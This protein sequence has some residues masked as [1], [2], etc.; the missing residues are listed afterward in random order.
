MSL[1]SSTIMPS[2]TFRHISVMVFF[3]ALLMGFCAFGLISVTSIISGWTKDI[4][5]TITIEIPAFDAQKKVI[6]GNDT[7]QNQ[8]Q[9]VIDVIENDPAI[10][11]IKSYRPDTKAT[12][13]NRFD[14]PAPVFLTL[15]LHTDRASNT[16]ERIA[17]S[18]QESTPNAIIKTPTEWIQNIQTTATTLYFVFMGLMACVLGVTAFVVAGVIRSQLTASK[19]TITLIH[20]CGA[21]ASQITNLFQSVVIKTVLKGCVPSLILMALIITPL[22]TYLNFEGSLGLYWLSLPIIVL[23]FVALTVIVTLWTVSNALRDM[24]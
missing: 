24:P 10:I 18:I 21:P 13:D 14:I 15:Y 4:S 1:S 2:S 3:M 12:A 19:E 9:I 6:L 22:A 5:D 23:M 8:T 20:L 16:E 17:K 7:I 11:N